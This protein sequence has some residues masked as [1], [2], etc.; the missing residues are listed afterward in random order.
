LQQNRLVST[1]T[2]QTSCHA[3]FGISVCSI[4]LLVAFLFCKQ[5]DFKLKGPQHIPIKKLKKPLP[6][7]KDNGLPR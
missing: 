2:S 4:L 5:F 6:I 3:R 1:T 7:T